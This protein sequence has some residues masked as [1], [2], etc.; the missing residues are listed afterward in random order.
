MLFITY[1]MN[2]TISL[3]NLNFDD[4]QITIYGT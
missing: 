2:N 3:A 4:K 1:K